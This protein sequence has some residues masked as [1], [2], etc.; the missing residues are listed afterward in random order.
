MFDK[1]YALEALDLLWDNH[2]GLMRHVDP[3]EMSEDRI[4]D[5]RRAKTTLRTVDLALRLAIMGEFVAAWCLWEYFAGQVCTGFAK[6]PARH[7]QE[8]FPTWVARTYQANGHTF[9]DAAWFDDA[10]ALRNLV[11]HN[12]GRVDATNRPKFE[13]ACR[14]FHRISEDGDGY[15]TL[16]ASELGR[17]N[18]MIEW[19][20]Q[21]AP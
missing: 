7:K 9:A 14:A 5:L 6:C 3:I 17:V 18:N 13:R 2:S 15:I 4:E 16:H 12:G 8:S 1:K 10:V 20:L 11:A 19:F 21:S